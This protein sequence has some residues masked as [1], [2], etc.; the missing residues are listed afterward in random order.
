MK[1]PQRGLAAGGGGGGGGERK[2]KGM[3][4]YGR[5]GMSGGGACGGGREEEEE[6]GVLGG[7]RGETASLR[8]RGALW[9]LVAGG[10]VERDGG[11]V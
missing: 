7:E 4:W 11:R 8:N 2:G 9:G 3:E 5:W 10:V 1:E 6:A